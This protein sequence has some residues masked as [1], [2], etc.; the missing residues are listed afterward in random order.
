V[1]RAGAVLAGIDAASA[2]LPKV[3][4]VSAAAIMSEQ[5]VVLMY[6]F[7]KLTPFEK[8]LIRRRRK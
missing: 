4:K 6:F 5:M 1:R 8:H 7:K 3:K 2:L